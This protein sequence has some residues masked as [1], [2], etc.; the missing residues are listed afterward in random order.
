[1]SDLGPLVGR[2]R[3]REALEAFLLRG[4]RAGGACIL[5]GEAGVGKTRLLHACEERARQLEA[6]VLHASGVQYEA[7]FPFAAL[8][9]I[10][11]PLFARLSELRDASAA[12][13]RTALGVSTSSQPVQ[14]MAV[15]EAALSLLEIAAQET[16]LLLLIDD[17][18][19][20]DPASAAALTFITHRVDGH[21]IAIISV[22][23]DGEP[24][25]FDAAG[26]PSYAIAPLSRAAADE[27]LSAR[28]PDMPA[29]VRAHLVRLSAGFPLALVEW[30]ADV[31]LALDKDDLPLP[32]SLEIAFGARISRLPDDGRAA[33]L[34]L[35]IDGRSDLSAL[36]AAGLSLPSLA[37]AERAHAVTV[38]EERGSVSFRH[39]LFRSALI[40]ASTH[41]ERR[42][43]HLRLA[44]SPSTDPDRRTWHLAASATGTDDAVAGM[45]RQLA[46]R[47]FARGDIVGATTAL[48]RAASLSN[49]PKD[50]ARLLA[51]AAF[52]GAD[53]TGEFNRAARLL[54]DA[55]AEL[56]TGPGSLYAVVAQAQLDVNADGDHRAALE[57]IAQA[58]H[59]GTHGWRADDDELIS[60]FHTWLLL[61]S[62][63]GDSQ[64]WETYFDDIRRLTP[65]PPELLLAESWAV[66]DTARNGSRAKETV[67]RLAKTQ[68]DESDPEVHTAMIFSAM[69]L[70]L[71]DSWSPSA[72]RFVREGRE[73]GPPRPYA[74]CLAYL[75][76]NDFTRGRW[77][78]G[79]ALSEEGAEVC[80]QHNFG[81]GAW[82]FA[83]T[84]ALLAAGRG[85]VEVARERSA[86]VDSESTR[87]GSWGAQRFSVLPRVLAAIAESDWED[88][89]RLARRLSAPGT[90]P[91][92]SA[93][94]MWVAFDLVEA[95]VRTGRTGEARAHA[96]AM[97][98]AG[99]EQVSTRIALL[100]RGAAAVTSDHDGW[101]E[102]F[103]E[104]LATPEAKTWPF[105][106]ARIE[107]AF[108][109]RLRRAGET[110]RARK[111]LHNALDIFENLGALPWVTRAATDLRAAGDARPSPAVFGYT[112]AHLTAQETAIAE[113]AAS[114]LTNKEIGSRLFL[115]PR[116]VSG[117]LYSIFP[118]LGIRSRAGLRDALAGRPRADE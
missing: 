2:E 61:C 48:I 99:I 14:P 23:R 77:E 21:R 3:E 71:V 39:P 89:Y 101:T 75:A 72:W 116:T 52:I 100:T 70:D 27:L 43:V 76:V 9:Q 18:H 32:R 64:H 44:A 112:V 69:Y 42:A 97:E 91:R 111:H 56:G 24:S 19:W 16:P 57:S 55:R 83:Y 114:G 106:L 54:A 20:V 62:Y 60:T 90:L 1:M 30:S 8:H 31:E 5:H 118:K 93:P 47:S 40:N 117:H 81:N 63:A 65:A 96:H 86:F 78:Q 84:N 12:A 36:T 13:L 53:M 4:L 10:L 45:L 34:I 88:A 85:D 87:R 25:H 113:L 95:A 35:A 108:G 103:E 98:R 41:E 11:R 102:A 7:D 104:A 26:I 58:V 51:E 59:N 28:Q 6:H 66:G 107:L 49:Q 74:R 115:S 110:S 37:D 68:L 80:R 82:Y 29:M 73:G 67:L 17:I 15:Y 38:D 94:A 79:L 50:R 109:E 33:L 22:L 105:D 46:H 92:H